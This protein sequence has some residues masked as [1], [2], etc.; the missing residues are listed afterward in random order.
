MG[1]GKLVRISN[2]TSK[3]LEKVASSTQI[4]FCDSVLIACLHRRSLSSVSIIEEIVESPLMRI[5]LPQDRFHTLL[6]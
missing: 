2:V 1:L 6:R 4:I 5:V 3:V